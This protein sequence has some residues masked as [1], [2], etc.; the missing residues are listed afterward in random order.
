MTEGNPRHGPYPGVRGT[1]LLIV[2]AVVLALV[3]G[4]LE[5]AGD[6]RREVAAVPA[7]ARQLLDLAAEAGALAVLRGDPAAARQLVRT[8][9]EQPAVVSAQVVGSGGRLLAEAS[10]A[11]A[12]QPRGWLVTRLFPLRESYVATLGDG[13]GTRGE[14]RLRFDPAA[15]HADFLARNLQTMLLGLVRNLVLLAAM[16]VVFRR[17]LGRPLRSV[18]EAMAELRPEQAAAARLR[19]PAGHEND[20]VGAV[21]ESGNRLLA[22]VQKRLG[23][24]QAAEA[25]A[26]LNE[27]RY[28]TLYDAM[29]VTV[30]T[31]D[32]AGVVVLV[33]QYGAGE[34][35]YGPAELIGAP[36]TR[37]YAEN[38]RKRIESLLAACFSEPHRTHVWEAWRVRRDGSELRGRE[39]ARVV[40]GEDG[41]Q[42]LL[43]VCEDITEAHDLATQ[44]A[45]QASHDPLT[46][47]FNRRA[48]EQRLETAM[49]SAREQGVEHVLCY[50][51]LDRFKQINDSCGHVAGDELLRE[52]AALLRE[53][54]RRQDSLAR[55]GGD[56]FGV[57]MEYC[58]VEQAGRVAQQLLEAV[59]RFTF[60]WEKHS[61]RIGVSIGMVAVD[62]QSQGLIR[63]MK[64]ADSAC[65]AAKTEGRHRVH[66][67]RANDMELSRQRSEMRWAG[68]L[69]EALERDSFEIW[70]QPIVSL[71]ARTQGPGLNHELLLRLK[72]GPHALSPRALMAAAERYSLGPS[73]DRWVIARALEQLATVPREAVQEG[74][75][76]I[77]LSG[78]SFSEPGFL[79]FVSG[80]FR[81]TG[82]PHRLI[83][84]EITE[85]AAVAN[86]GAAVNF[87]HELAGLGCRFALDD[88]GSGFSSFAHLR[89]LPVHYLKIDGSFVRDIAADRIHEGL[90]RAISDLAHTLGVSTV[91]E[92]VE[93]AATVER[94]KDLGVDYAQ[95]Y[96]LGRPRPLAAQLDL[97]CARVG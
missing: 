20:A 5:L 26:R 66:V 85:T 40:G 96:F 3:F 23:A 15:F 52:L 22:A 77:N 36:F 74:Q 24:Q 54:V 63:V 65:Y 62:A 61:F 89:N 37:F 47:L 57:L 21:V 29:P 30:F 97:V 1:R 18:A 81:R 84:F 39:T 44:L 42:S 51:D 31:V 53:Q 32:Q 50:L 58:T 43:V 28:R 83:C 82:T 95:G 46:G 59:E 90:V 13:V 60:V 33:N 79:D 86:M 17:W 76:S 92:H 73:L 56:E 70:A 41:Q 87:I 88:F 35:G 67:Y 64:A 2:T 48:F 49:V 7:Q 34:L 38:E 69:R 19:A 71:G 6:Y 68:R 45:Y 27:R 4:A 93:D 78:S 75:W 8:L 55:L 12:Q 14:L 72:D 11:S 25:G 91:A 16:L 9:L 10:R 80:E 94:L